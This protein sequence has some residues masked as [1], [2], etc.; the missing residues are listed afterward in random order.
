MFCSGRSGRHHIGFGLGLGLDL[1]TFNLIRDQKSLGPFVYNRIYRKS[2]VGN[3]DFRS[4]I[5][6]RN[7]DDAHF[8]L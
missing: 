7:D 1:I 2:K 3:L 8:S 6:L 5:Y 4:D